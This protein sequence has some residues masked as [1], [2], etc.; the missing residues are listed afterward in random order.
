M[1]KKQAGKGSEASR[2]KKILF[3]FEILCFNLHSEK[4]IL[5]V[6]TSVAFSMFQFAFRED[7]TNS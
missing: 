2:G 4:I 5:I 7:N 3:Q 1:E 6:K